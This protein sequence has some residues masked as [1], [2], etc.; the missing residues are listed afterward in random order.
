MRG[1]WSRSDR[2]HLHRAGRN[3]RDRKSRRPF[4]GVG[5]SF[6][7]GN[8]AGSR[9]SPHRDAGG[10]AIYREPLVELAHCAPLQSVSDP[11]L[12]WS[13]YYSGD[14]RSHGSGRRHHQS[15]SRRN[16]RSGIREGGQSSVAASPA[17][18]A[19]RCEHRQ[20]R[21]VDPRP[22]RGARRGRE[23]DS[24]RENRRLPIDH[25]PRAPVCCR[26]PRYSRGQLHQE[27]GQEDSPMRAVT[28][29]EIMLRLAP[30]G[31]ERFLQTPQFTATFGGA[32][33]NVAVALASFGLTAT[34]VTVL[35]PNPIADAAIAELVRFG[36]DTSQII[37]AKGRLGIY[38]LES[39]ASQ[40]PSKVVYDR[41]Y[42]S[43]ALAKPGD[44]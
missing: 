31:F 4:P 9:D 26:D 23:P 35:P 38:Y 17:H 1:R 41:E 42:S 34:Y 14:R 32:E 40:R 15:L 33:A 6:G 28:F 5:D 18:A 39:G 21:R 44:I 12:A 24:R 2:N 29:G 10:R 19:G 30:P 7:R 25:R 36:V 13:R 11:V 20:C 8:R 37:R 22:P 16:A 27:D 43:I 3:R